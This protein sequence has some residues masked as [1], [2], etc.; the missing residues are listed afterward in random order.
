MAEGAS[1]RCAKC[2]IL[3]MLIAKRGSVRFSEKLGSEKLGS[4]KLGLPLFS[5]YFLVKFFYIVVV[6]FIGIDGAIAKL[7]AIPLEGCAIALCRIG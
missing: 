5:I 6:G 7:G 2:P 1:Q 4:E 3:T